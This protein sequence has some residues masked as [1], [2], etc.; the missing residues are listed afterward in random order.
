M[1][2][3]SRRPCAHATVWCLRILT[4][5]L[6]ITPYTMRIDMADESGF[7]SPQRP[8]NWR[9]RAQRRRGGG[10]NHPPRGGS[11]RGSTNR[12][13]F[14]Q[15]QRLS[16]L[17]EQVMSYVRSQLSSGAGISNSGR[18][19]SATRRDRISRPGDAQ[20]SDQRSSSIPEF[21]D[22]GRGDHLAR[23]TTSDPPRSSSVAALSD[24]GRE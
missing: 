9:V 8:R 2:W 24:T 20:H 11:I 13:N 5:L 15:H 22:T 10:I 23:S 6:S 18:G 19:G 16:D 1:L 3:P 17:M 14:Y 7:G 12:L 4:R 21:I